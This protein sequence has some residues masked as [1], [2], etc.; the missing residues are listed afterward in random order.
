MDRAI[1]TFMKYQ[2]DAE[3]RFMKAEEERWKREME[4][5]EKRRSQEQE[6]EMRMMRMI[7]TM[8]YPGG[9]PNYGDY[10]D[11]GEYTDY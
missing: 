7:M 10:N 4:Y 3:E 11:I 1:E 6:H 8:Q 2:S 5:E 9:P